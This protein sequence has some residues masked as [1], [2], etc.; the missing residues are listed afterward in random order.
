MKS[1]IDIH[2]FCSNYLFFQLAFDEFLNS[3]KKYLS[4][5]EDNMQRE[6]AGFWN[7]FKLRKNIFLFI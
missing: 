6:K 2:F 3:I 1:Q 7:D 5:I 4:I